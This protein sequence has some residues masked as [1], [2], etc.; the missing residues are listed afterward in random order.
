MMT[1]EFFSN[2]LPDNVSTEKKK[3]KEKKRSISTEI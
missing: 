1:L 3:R 2:I